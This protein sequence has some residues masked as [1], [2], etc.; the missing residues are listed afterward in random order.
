VTY[1]SKVTTKMD[2][3]PHHDHQDH[4]PHPHPHPALP[5]IAALHEDITA[6]TLSSEAVWEQHTYLSK[7]T[8]KTDLRFQ[9]FSNICIICNCSMVRS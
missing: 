9:S 5:L 6:G 7:V 8:T 4:H 2:N 3:Y 1:L